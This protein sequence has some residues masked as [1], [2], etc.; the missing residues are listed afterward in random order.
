MLSDEEVTEILEILE[1]QEGIRQKC[2]MLGLMWAGPYAIEMSE[3]V[4]HLLADRAV[5][6]AELVLCKNV[7]SEL[8]EADALVD[9]CHK[10][11]VAEL[12]ARVERLEGR[13]RTVRVSDEQIEQF[14]KTEPEIPDADREEGYWTTADAL[15]DLQELRATARAVLEVWR[16]QGEPG[17]DLQAE[18]EAKDAL[19]AA[20]GPGERT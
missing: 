7:V 19:R 14:L 15:R 3:D 9:K 8:K 17:P 6:K 20:L 5:L 12:K 4:K 18:V 16:I 13:R 10:R 11:E 1:D 2:A